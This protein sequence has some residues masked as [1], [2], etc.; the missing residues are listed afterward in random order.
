MEYKPNNDDYLG[1]LRFNSSVHWS[2]MIW[3]CAIKSDPHVINHCIQNYRQKTL[4]NVL[5]TYLLYPLTGKR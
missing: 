1:L 4:Q 2:Q 3:D 5:R